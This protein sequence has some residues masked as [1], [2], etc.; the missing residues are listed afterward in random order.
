MQNPTR[1]EEICAPYKFGFCLQRTLLLMVK[2]I[3]DGSSIQQHVGQKEKRQRNYFLLALSK[4]KF[5][6]ENFH[7]SYI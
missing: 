3:R 7:F 5:D 6:D 1:R 2:T 4:R